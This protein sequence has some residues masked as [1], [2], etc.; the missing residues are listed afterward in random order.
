VRIPHEKIQCFDI[1]KNM[2]TLVF[3]TTAGHIYIYDLPN[4]LENERILARKKL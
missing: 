4:A 2:T 3:G 1:D